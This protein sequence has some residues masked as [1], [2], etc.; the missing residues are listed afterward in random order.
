MKLILFGGV[1]K[2]LPKVRQVL[3]VSDDGVEREVPR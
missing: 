3:M 2:R 1:G